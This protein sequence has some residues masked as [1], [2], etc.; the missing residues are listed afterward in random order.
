MDFK[1]ISKKQLGQFY[2]TNYKYI[3]QNFSI[4]EQI[5]FIIEPFCGK[6][7]LLPFVH[8]N[9]EIGVECYD[10]E[11]KK[12]FISKRD[13]F[14]N[15]P[16]YTNKFVITNPPYLARNKSKSKTIFDKYHQND[17]YKCFIQQ[18]ILDPCEGGILIIPLNFWCS[19]RKNDIVLRKQFLE[20]YRING[21]NI[22]EETVFE[23]TSYTICSFQFEF[24]PDN[25]KYVSATLYP[26]QKKISSVLEKQN[27]FMFG[28]EVYHLKKNKQYKINRLIQGQ[29]PNTN[30]LVKCIDDNSKN[31]IGMKIVQ[32]DEIY[33]DQTPNQSSRT[34]ATLMIEPNLTMEQQEN[35][36]NRFNQFLNEKRETY[37]SLFLT[38]YR[39]SKNNSARKRISFDLVYDIVSHVI[40]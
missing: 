28:G 35:V 31:P 36:V 18:L 1:R 16:S 27:S 12:D 23:D 2:T 15:P 3:L 24:Q 25:E 17:L 13:V 39:E 33:V 32:D 29:I 20:L 14:E 37:H 34:Y 9:S 7:D 19:I 30:I 21:I 40:Q 4:P 8:E 22:F 10:I 38:N 5:K 6:G 11:P 26:S